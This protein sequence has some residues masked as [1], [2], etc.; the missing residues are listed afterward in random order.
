[1]AEVTEGPSITRVA[2]GVFAFLLPV[3]YSSTVSGAAW[4]PK[5]AVLLVALAVGLPRLVTLI[6]SDARIPAIAGCALVA[7]AVLSTALSSH[8]TVSVI[9]LYNWGTGLLFVAA[10]PAVW[11]IGASVGEDGRKLVEGGLLTAVAVNAA[12]AVF[13]AATPANTGVLTRF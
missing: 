8:P 11:A 9:G 10:L 4:S 7:A 1:M 13:Q 5:A 2:A 3:A 12:V 6:W